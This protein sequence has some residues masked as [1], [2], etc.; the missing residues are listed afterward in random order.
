MEAVKVT[1]SF[2]PVEFVVV[3]GKFNP[4]RNR[5]CDCESKTNRIRELVE[6]PVLLELERMELEFLSKSIFLKG[7]CDEIL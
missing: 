6:K 1:P 3:V 7:S 4:R 5:M 2:Q